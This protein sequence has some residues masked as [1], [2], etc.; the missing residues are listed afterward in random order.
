MKKTYFFAFLAIF[1]SMGGF[2]SCQKEFNRP[3]PEVTTLS[4]TD[5][6]TDGFLAHGHIEN[7]GNFE[8]IEM[9]FLYSR[10]PM[11][12]ESISERVVAEQPVNSGKFS[13]MAESALLRT[14]YYVRAYVRTATHIVFGPYV[15]VRAMGGK[16]PEI[17]DFYPKVALPGDVVQIQGRYFSY[18][19]VGNVVRLNNEQGMVSGSTD[20]TIHF[21]VPPQVKEGQYDLVLTVANRTATASE[22]IT[23][24]STGGN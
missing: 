1:V 5:I 2:L 20:T 17:Y 6:S 23:I 4:A 13:L 24:G 9:G 22:K 18:S 10:N 7:R 12:N 8:V 14:D 11:F 21:V 19:S 15:E 16:A 3:Y